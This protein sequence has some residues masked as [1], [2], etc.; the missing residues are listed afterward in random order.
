[1]SRRL[2]NHISVSQDRTFLESSLPLTMELADSLKAIILPILEEN[3]SSL[4]FHDRVLCWLVPTMERDIILFHGGVGPVLSESF[5]TQA[6]RHLDQQFY[7]RLSEAVEQIRPGIMGVL[8]ELV[9]E[10]LGE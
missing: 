2:S 3:S 6:V 8:E 1:M 10:P 7:L 4:P 9:V 5:N